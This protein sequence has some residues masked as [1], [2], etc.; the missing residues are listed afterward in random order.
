MGMA[1]STGSPAS[2]GETSRRRP[3]VLYALSPVQGVA[4][5]AT[6]GLVGLTILGIVF[7]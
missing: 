5:P 3:E 7:R 6:H 1:D 2:S 4:F